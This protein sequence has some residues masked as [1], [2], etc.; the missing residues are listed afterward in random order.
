[1][2]TELETLPVKL[3]VGILFSDRTACEKALLSLTRKFGAADYETK[4]VLFTQTDYYDREM[5][6]PIY[7]MFMA[8]KKLVLPHR[9]AGIKKWSDTLEKRFTKNGNRKVNVDPGYISLNNLVLATTKNYGH[10]IALSSSIYAE[11]TLMYQKGA[12]ETLPWT[13][14]DYRDAA[15]I[16]HF[17][18]IRRLLKEQYDQKGLLQKHVKK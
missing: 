6:T 8:F 10:R 11:V 4:P 3:I 2:G 18:E 12:F 15:N 14:P 17:T 9:I 13:Y 7:R 5:G 16:P 1:M